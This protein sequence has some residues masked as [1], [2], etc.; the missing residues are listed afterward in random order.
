MVGAGPVG[1]RR[2]T[3]L[4]EAGAQ[5]VQVAPNA[6]EGGIRARFAS[7]HLDDVCLVFACATPDVNAQ[8]AAA[9]RARG[10]LVGRADD[11]RAGDFDVPARSRRGALLVSMGTGGAAPAAT[12]VLREALEARIPHGWASIVDEV[13]EARAHLDPDA[14]KKLAR[15]LLATLDEPT[16]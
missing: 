4:R 15:R 14:Q 1:S 11:P 9:A 3:A 13:A 8:V 10:L 12:R 2:A 16:P 6:P 5:V 7:E